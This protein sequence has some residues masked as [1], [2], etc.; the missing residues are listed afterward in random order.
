MNDDPHLFSVTELTLRIKSTLEGN[1]GNIALT[2]EVSNFKIHTSGHCY[3]TLKDEQ[4]QISAVMWRTRVANLPFTP[5]NGMKVVARGK[6]SVYPVR[7]VYQ[8]D[9]MTMQPAGV[10]ELQAAFERLKNRLFEEGLF[11]DRHK[12]PLPAYP[13]SVG[14]VTSGS[15]AA[16]RDMVN[17]LSRRAPYLELILLPVSVQGP[18]AAAEIAGA[19]RAFNDYGK[20]DLLI[21]GRGGGSIEDLWAF[22]EEVV[23]RAIFQSKI[24]VISAVG[25]EV[26]FTIADFV[27]DL[28]A[29][30]PSAAAELAVRAKE[31]LVENLANFY[32]TARNIAEARIAAH[33]EKISHYLKSYAFA[34]PA[35]LVRQK[36]Q[37]L[38]DLTGT[39]SRIAGFRLA[40]VRQHIGGMTKRLENLDPRKI[41]ERG[42][43]I[44]SKGGKAVSTSKNL[45]PGD[46]FSLRFHDGTIP[47][48]AAE[49]GSDTN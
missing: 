4:S 26:D 22:N 27:A 40:T 11:D 5:E 21:V 41:L 46:R 15:G 35:D 19:I 9:V 34:L 30:T 36:S 23:A 29:P 3:F 31:E 25:H 44:V 17:V 47:G 8:I 1:F 39:I 38:D 12:L 32:Y 20:V 10:G 13:V 2:G 33:R 45:R 24:P 18:G 42:F 37:Q 14:L 49:S 28:R 48:I 6:I 16:V 7:G 43:V